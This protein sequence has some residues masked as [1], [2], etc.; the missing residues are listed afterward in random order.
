MELA[1][2]HR[3][4]LAGATATSAIALSDAVTHGVTGGYSPFSDDSDLQTLVAT[5]DVVHG[6]TYVALAVVLL[7]EAE[8]FRGTNRLARGSRW[9]VLVSLAVLAVGF[10]FLA[11]VIALRDAYDSGVY[12]GFSV[13]GAPAFFGMIF[14]SL[15]LG[16]A[17]LRNRSLGVGGR[18]LALMTPVFGGMMLLDWLAPAWAHPAYLETTL[19]FGLA[20]IGV[21]ALAA[22][23]ATREA[24]ASPTSAV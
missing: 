12:T 20:L 6:L 10:L 7:R 16:L 1:S 22:Q 24:I 5:A 15:T 21:G 19:H 2:H 14:G 23:P 9:V 4:A 8:R 17:V 11:P 13:V 18:V 3:W